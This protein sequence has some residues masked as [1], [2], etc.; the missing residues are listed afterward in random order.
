MTLAG[1]QTR[2]WPKP[3][4][5]AVQD[6]SDGPTWNAESGPKQGVQRI[7]LVAVLAGL[8]RIVSPARPAVELAKS[9]GLEVRTSEECCVFGLDGFND[10]GGL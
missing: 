7:A 9:L 2:P 8:N 6:L 10:G 4:Q 1:S 5:A 3:S